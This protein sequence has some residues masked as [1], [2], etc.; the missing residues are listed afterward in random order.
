M[1]ETGARPHEPEHLV[2]GQISKAHGNRGEVVVWP[3]TDSPDAVFV[4]EA[5]LLVGDADGRVDDE[6]D[7]LFI[8][9]SRPFKEA[10]LVHFDGY[11]D[12]TAVEELLGLYVL[13]PRDALPPLEEGELFY[14]QLLGMR[15]ATVEGLDVGRVRE[16]FETEPTHLL[17]VQDDDGRVRLIPFAAHIVK[18]T[19]VAGGRI[20]ID[21]PEGLLEI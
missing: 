6:A 20:V 14:H 11:D 21:P 17:E 9:S 12:R 7:E 13:A 8:V 3:L 18:E 4:P 10:V 1:A 2:V 5:E 15:V 19:D 16:V